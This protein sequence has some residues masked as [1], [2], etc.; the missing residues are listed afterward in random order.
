MTVERPKIPSKRVN[1]MKEVKKLSAAACEMGPMVSTIYDSKND[2]NYFLRSISNPHVK[3][4]KP[5]MDDDDEEQKRQR[6][7][8]IAQMLYKKQWHTIS[9]DE[10]QALGLD[11]ADLPFI[12][13][14]L[15]Q[16]KNKVSVYKNIF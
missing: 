6:L 11:P 15:D 14:T 12:F 4:K 8:K 16:I 3:E 1:P 9:T 13:I 5:K 10:Q 7:T 2:K